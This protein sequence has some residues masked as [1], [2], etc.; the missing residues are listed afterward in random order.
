MMPSEVGLSEEQAGDTRGPDFFSRTEAGF[1][2]GGELVAWTVEKDGSGIPHETRVAAAEEGAKSR[3]AAAN[4]DLKPGGQPDCILPSHP[5]GGGWLA[6]LAVLNL[7]NNALEKVPEQLQYLISLR[8]LHLF[9]NMIATVSPDIFA[10][11]ENLNF[12]N[13]N[14]NMLQSIPP[15][16]YR[17]QSLGYLSL[18][19]NQLKSVPK[20][21]GLLRSLSELHLASNQLKT[22]PEEVGYMIS[23]SKL[24]LSRNQLVDLPE[25]LGKLKHLKILDVAGNQIRS[26]PSAIEQLP[27]EEFYCEE[28]PLLQKQPVLSV[29]EEEILS[30]AEITARYILKHIKSPDSILRIQL[31][32]YPEA[33][34]ILSHK[35]VCAVCGQGF[36][37]MWL[38][39]VKFVVK[40]KKIRLSTNVH[41]LPIRVFLC[42]YKCFNQEDHGLF[43]VAVP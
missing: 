30:L 29:H 27:L 24:Y 9:G 23:L 32:L 16:I 4:K 33:R 21:I 40:T 36:L 20:Q 28:N 15:E 22:L 25:G 17:L 26:F 11:L 8:K 38:E 3:G 42:S 2:G 14:N 7:G 10:G 1:P 18:N 6:K 37:N 19:N 35:N 12:L 43:G 13:L 34:R 39:C 31:K 41:L 5:P